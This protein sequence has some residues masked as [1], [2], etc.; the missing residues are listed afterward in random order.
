MTTTENVGSDQKILPPYLT[1]TK[2]QRL[3]Q[4]LSTRREI[5]AD[6]LKS[7]FGTNDGYLAM[8]VLRF[9]KLIDVKGEPQEDIKKFF[10]QGEKRKDGLASIVKSGYARLFATLDA[11]QDLPIEELT[12]EFI[13]LYDVSPRVA[14]SAVP[15]FLYLCMEAGM[16][17]VETRKRKIAS[18]PSGSRVRQPL[19]KKVDYGPSRPSTSEIEAQIENNPSYCIS[20]PAGIKLCIPNDE[21]LIKVVRSQEYSQTEAAINNLLRYYETFNEKESGP[22]DA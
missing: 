15:A 4:L 17:T 13:A 10:I 22:K 8:G 20:F 16:K 19:R 12:N 21:M 6:Y 5:N 18:P 3:V 2:L 7:Q 9:L 11:P 1:I 14:R